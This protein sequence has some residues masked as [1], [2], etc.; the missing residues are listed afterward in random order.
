MSP[1]DT[2]EWDASYPP[3]A[4]LH[5]DGSNPSLAGGMPGTATAMPR[6]AQPAS[7]HA[8]RRGGQHART[9]SSSLHA[10]TMPAVA[11]PALGLSPAGGWA[12][13]GSAPS[14]AE[15][16]ELWLSTDVLRERDQRPPGA[17]DFAP[18]HARA[19][20]PTSARTDAPQVVRHARSARPHRTTTAPTPHPPVG[21]G[22][23]D[24]A[25]VDADHHDP[26]GLLNSQPVLTAK[27]SEKPADRQLIP[28]RGPSRLPKRR[29]P[30]VPAARINGGSGSAPSP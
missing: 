26:S 20:D 5:P 24:P 23:P 15:L 10:A 6:A 18:M 3:R 30:R 25:R 19:A 14:G 12:F 11:T 17:A 28:A 4:E 13:G 9:R 16:T 29:H 2:T 1:S 21:P 7:L 22:R 27:N 8:R